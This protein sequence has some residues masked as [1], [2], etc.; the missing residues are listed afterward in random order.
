MKNGRQSRIREKQDTIRT[1][2][3]GCTNKCRKMLNWQKKANGQAK[4]NRNST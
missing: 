2:E 4:S 1:K 3:N